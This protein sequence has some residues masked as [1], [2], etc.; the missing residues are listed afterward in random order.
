MRH[1]PTQWAAAG[2]Q[3]TL[4]VELRGLVTASTLRTLS[5]CRTCQQHEDQVS[6]AFCTG[7]SRDG[8]GRM[9]LAAR[10]RPLIKLSAVHGTVPGTVMLDIHST[11]SHSRRC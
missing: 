7:A 8:F 4:T 2:M 5:E 1:V 9:M 11:H 10:E 3:D 6:Y